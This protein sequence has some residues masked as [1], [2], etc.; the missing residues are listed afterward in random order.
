MAKPSSTWDS[1]LLH[2]RPLII[3][4]GEVGHAYNLLQESFFNIFNLVMALERSSDPTTFYPYALAM[5]HVFQND[6]QQRQ[7]ALAAL[8]N[9]PTTLDI[10]GGIARLQWAQKQTDKLASYRNL[11][12][13]TP[14]TFSYRIKSSKRLLSIPKI[15]SASTKPIDRRRLRLIKDLRFWKGLRNDLLNL[16]DYVDFVIRQLAWRWYE[17]RQAAPVPGASHAWPRRPRLRSVRRIDSIEPIV[18]NPR[19]ARRPRRVRRKPSPRRSSN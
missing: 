12:V 17:N 9:I 10:K 16:N 1:A 3:A 8:A 15:G 4:Q 5:W 7:L 2:F 18:A 13:H 19:P 14:M 6:R 11:I